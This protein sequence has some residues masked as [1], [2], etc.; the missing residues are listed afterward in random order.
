MSTATFVTMTGGAKP[1]DRPDSPS[2][3]LHPSGAATS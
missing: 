2:P 1:V 3:H